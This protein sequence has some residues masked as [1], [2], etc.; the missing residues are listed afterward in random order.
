MASERRSK[1]PG[2]DQLL[3]ERV[4]L[5]RRPVAPV[6]RLRAGQLRHLLDPGH[7]LLVLRRDGRLAHVV[8]QL[9][10]FAVGPG[11]VAH[12]RALRP[13]RSRGMRRPGLRTRQRSSSNQ[14]NV[15]RSQAVNRPGSRLPRRPARRPSTAGPTRWTPAYAI[16]RFIR[17]SRQ[18]RRGV[19][20]RAGLAAGHEDEPLEL[21]HEDAVLVVYAGV[22]PH[23]P[24]IGLGLRLAL[25]EH[26]GLH[27]QRVP[28]EDR[29]G[30]LE[31]LGGEVGDRLARDV[32]H[33]HPQR[34]RV[35]QR[36][37]D[38]V[39]SLLGLRGVDVVDVQ[40]VVVHGDQAEE[41]VVGLGHRLGGPVLVDGPD[42][43]LLEVAAVRMRPAGLAGGLVGL[44]RRRRGVGHRVRSLV[45]WAGQSI[46]PRSGQAAVGGGHT[47]ARR[48]ARRRRARRRAGPARRRQGRR[49]QR[50]RDGLA[51]GRVD[52][53]PARGGERLGDGRARAEAR[54]RRCRRAARSAGRRPPAR[55][56]RTRPAPSPE[57][58]RARSAPG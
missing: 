13:I 32:G 8:R 19:A 49:L 23:R 15:P 24:A 45:C 46:T 14:T 16:F 36:P 30:V 28:V 38:H 11:I 42:L 57:R 22:D 6:D 54:R 9:L 44:Q 43:E 53:P 31:L 34:Q 27:E 25:L 55:P 2:V 29:R 41:V 26:L 58:P 39:A 21:G 17:R 4:V 56:A 40:R 7:E 5:L 50:R 1:V 18:G 48:R 51:E 3:G 12:P 20:R 33:A 47:I 10:R 35:D 37:D 52:G